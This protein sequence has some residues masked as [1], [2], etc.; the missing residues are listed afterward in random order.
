VAELQRLRPLN[1]TCVVDGP[2]AAA[3]HPLKVRFIEKF[4][5]T[6]PF[7]ATP[8]RGGAN[9]RLMP[10]PTADTSKFLASTRLIVNALVAVGYPEMKMSAAGVAGDVLEI[11]PTLFMASLLPP[12]PYTGP[13]GQHTDDL[14]LKLVGRSTLNG[15]VRTHPSLRPYGSLIS[16]VESSNSDELHDLRAAAISAIAAHWLA[17]APPGCGEG[18]ALMLIGHPVECGF[19]LPSRSAC[20]P[21]FF[22]MLETHWLAAGGYGLVWALL[23]FP[24]V[25][26]RD[27]G[28]S[29]GTHRS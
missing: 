28:A 25:T 20:D 7:A 10:A 29:A 11:F 4:F 26:E 21:L 3:T 27:R 8:I 6:G 19:L 24:W 17:V 18:N 1:V 13:R 9:L 23:T 16:R 15:I 5:M 22:A 14:W 12:H 2:F